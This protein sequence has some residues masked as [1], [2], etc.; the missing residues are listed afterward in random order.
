MLCAGAMY[1]YNVGMSVN[2]PVFVR[3]YVRFVLPKLDLVPAELWPQ[4]Y[5]RPTLA[6]WLHHHAALLKAEGRWTGS[7]ERF[8]S[9]V[10]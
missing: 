1:D 4:S 8:L 3:M 6:A 7:V 5:M 2:H 9:S 10:A